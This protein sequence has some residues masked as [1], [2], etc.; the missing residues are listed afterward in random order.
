MQARD[1][2]NIIESENH[3]LKTQFC[4]VP[5][6][7]TPDRNIYNII[8]NKYKDLSFFAVFIGMPI[9]VLAAVFFFTVIITVPIALIFGWL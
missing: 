4:N 9:C 7:I 8:R 3:E 1:L 6:T 5:F 2:K